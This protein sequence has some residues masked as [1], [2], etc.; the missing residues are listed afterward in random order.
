M[1]PGRL[2][3]NQKLARR[4]SDELSCVVVPDRDTPAMTVPIDPKKIAEL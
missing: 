4:I 3:R 2:A 1:V